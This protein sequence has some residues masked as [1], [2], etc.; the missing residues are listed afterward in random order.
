MQKMIYV[1]KLQENRFFIYFSES[2]QNSTIM[3]ECE[4]YYDY[5]KQY[6]PLFIIETFPFKDFLYVDQIVKQYM[7]HHGYEYVRGGSYIDNELPNYL[8]KTLN[9]EFENEHNDELDY[10]YYFNEILTKYENKNYLSV[11]E[12]NQEMFVVK[13][14]YAK[15]NIEKNA[16]K[17]TS[18]FYVDGE[19][20]NSKYFSSDDIIWLYH[21]CN[22]NMDSVIIKINTTEI[23]S[24]LN[25][26]YVKKYKYVLSY[27][28]HLYFLFTEYDLFSK[29]NIQKS[30]YLQYPNFLFDG[31]I[32]NTPHKDTQSI[33]E[34]YKTFLFMGN[35]IHNMLIEQEFD[36]NS[37]GIY[38]EWKVSRILYILESKKEY[39][40]S[41]K[42]I[43][44]E[45]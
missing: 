14:E 32:Y 24:V 43:F 42:L 22:V 30:I 16:L 44:P 38:Y 4:I 19:K 37:Y 6:K 1:I 9:H 34:I 29:Y 36:V 39:L 35:V 23:E 25:S 33:Y 20:K 12:I 28:K 8:V 5:V 45:E 41:S 10:R 15:Y 2:K 21:M 27:L 40:V 3:R 17:K 13:Q 18:F 7:Y 31:F 26:V 11:D